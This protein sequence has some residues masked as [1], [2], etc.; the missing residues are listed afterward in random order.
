MTLYFNCTLSSVHCTAPA[1]YVSERP[2]E[3]D[4][5][6]LLDHGDVLPV[7]LGVAELVVREVEPPPVPRPEGILAPLE[8]VTLD[9]GVFAAL[10]NGQ[11]DNGGKRSISLFKIYLIVIPFF[12]RRGKSL[13]KRRKKPCTLH[14]R[15]VIGSLPF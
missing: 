5:E 1:V 6:I 9:A 10:D 2:D 7:P 4:P 11:W 13:T 12:S 15:M 8:E 14:C 3:A